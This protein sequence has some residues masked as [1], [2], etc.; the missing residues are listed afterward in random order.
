MQ[1]NFS[2]FTFFLWLPVLHDIDLY[3]YLNRCELISIY[4]AILFQV[5]SN[6]SLCNNNTKNVIMSKIY[7]IL[8]FVHVNIVIRVTLWH[9]MGCVT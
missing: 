6:H 3:Y 9:P 8:C 1:Y 5:T 2:P 4:I 7:R